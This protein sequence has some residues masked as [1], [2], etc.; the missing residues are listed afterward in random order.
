VRER[1]GTA[2]V[3]RNF[4]GEGEGGVDKTGRSPRARLALL[5]ENA[6]PPQLMKL[7]GTDP[8]DRIRLYALQQVLMFQLEPKMP[9]D[10]VLRGQFKEASEQMVPLLEQIRIQKDMLANQPDIPEKFE[11][12]KDQL[13]EAYGRA[14][15]ARDALRKGGSREAVEAAEAAREQVWKAGMPMLSILV[16]GETAD[17]RRAQ[18]MYQQSLCMHEQ[19]ERQRAH[20][21]ALAHAA[22]PANAKELDRAK[23]GALTAWKDAASWWNNYTGS[24]PR[25][26]PG[27]QA[28]LLLARVREAQGKPDE[29][30]TLLEYAPGDFGELNRI[31]RLYLARRVKTP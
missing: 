23:E 3:L 9:R 17:S 16:D 1:E 24:F 12:W 14:S 7:K 21:D 29:A 20:A 8:G 5:P 22:P 25:T 4:L 28:R 27:I 30:R 19:A 6:L 11:R 10:L 13:F 15:E 18:V 2:G 26:P 31:N